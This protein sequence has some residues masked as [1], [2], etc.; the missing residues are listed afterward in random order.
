MKNSFLSNQASFYDRIESI[1]NT[2]LSGIPTHGVSSF[3][4]VINKSNEA[5]VFIDSELHIGL[6]IKP[7][8]SLVK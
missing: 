6:S 2:I 7:K 1:S 3:L 5:K 4:V 8:R